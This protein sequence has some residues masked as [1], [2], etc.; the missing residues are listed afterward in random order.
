MIEVPAAAL[1]AEAFARHLDFLSIGTNDLIQYTLAADRLDEEVSY[2]CDPLHPAILMLV[3]QVIE[4]GKKAGKPVAMCGE[5]AGNPRFTR[6]LLVLGLR[7]FSMNSSMLPRVKDIIM[8]SN[9]EDLRGRFHALQNMHHADDIAA[10]VD[11]I[12]AG[13]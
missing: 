8:Q 10:F 5:M 7:I 4:A 13:V 1:Q 3:L 11:Q 12:N 6:L 2:L 9:I